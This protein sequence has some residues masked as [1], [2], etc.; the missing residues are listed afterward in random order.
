M[1]KR[2]IINLIKVNRT[3]RKNKSLLSITRDKNFNRIKIDKEYWFPKIEEL[4]QE[5]KILESEVQDTLEETEKCLDLIKSSNCP[6]HIRLKHFGVFG[7]HSTCIFCDKTIMSDNCVN[8]EYSVN[9]NKYCVDLV[10][11]Y[12]DDEDYDYVKDGYTEEELYEIILEILKAKKDDEEVDL[13]QEFKKLNLNNSIITEK[14]IVKENYILIINGSNKQYIDE[15]SYIYKKHSD[16]GMEFL[17]Y[18]SSLLGTKIE[19][20]DSEKQNSELFQ[21]RTNHFIQYNSIE[22]LNQ[23]LKRQQSIPFKIIID[24]S[25]LYDYQIEED[26]IT[27]KEINLELEK[28]FPQSKII[29]IKNLSKARREELINYLNKSYNM[30]YAYQNKRYH[31]LENNELK[32]EDLD[33]TCSS[34]KKMLV[35]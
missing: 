4:S 30:L 10:A 7:S 6:H 25:E 5:F 21:N 23:I 15:D 22:E 28:L 31:S 33:T 24:I 1:T 26:K 18:F 34:I 2:E 35:N 8:W 19:L 12:Q 9:R 17:T 14:P 32:S 16:L 27:K 3:I 20:L 13:V 11:K 29:R